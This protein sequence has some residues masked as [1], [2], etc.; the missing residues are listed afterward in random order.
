MLLIDTTPMSPAASKSSDAGSG[1]L[2]NVTTGAGSSCADAAFL[3]NDDGLSVTPVKSSVS[4]AAVAES[5]E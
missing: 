1:T 2:A 4:M 3:V 5:F